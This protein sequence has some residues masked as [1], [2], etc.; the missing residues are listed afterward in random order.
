MG[1]W[2]DCER[3]ERKGKRGPYVACDG[4][5]RHILCH[6]PVAAGIFVFEH[7]IGGRIGYL[8]ARLAIRLIGS[9]EWHC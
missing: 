9:G 7:R 2:P 1:R 3:K 5:Q 6:R 4:D 8:I